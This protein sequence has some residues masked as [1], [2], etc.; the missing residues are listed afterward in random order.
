LIVGTAL[1]GLG[2]VTRTVALNH[3][4]NQIESGGDEKAYD[5]YILNSVLSYSLWA[6]G[7]VG[8]VLPF[9][10][11]IGRGKTEAQVTP[12]RPEKLRFERLQ[13]IPLPQGMVLR[14][15]Y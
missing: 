6:A 11:D 7:G 8:M 12:V 4:Q 5:R 13:L 15:S 10:T 3:R 1:V 14:I 9:V 2:S